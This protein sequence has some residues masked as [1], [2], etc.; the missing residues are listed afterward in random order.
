MWFTPITG[1]VST[2]KGNKLLVHAVIWM[3]ILVSERS[4]TSKAAYR[5][6]PFYE[7]CGRGQ[8]LQAAGRLEVVWSWGKGERIAFQQAEGDSWGVMAGF[9]T[10]I[11]VMMAKLYR[12]PKTP[13]KYIY[14]G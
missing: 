3:N 4:P 10:R 12:F 9:R 2:V 11:A 14:N 1:H 8:P 6:T 7:I 13:W 5:M